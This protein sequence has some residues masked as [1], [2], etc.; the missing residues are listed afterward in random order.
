MAHRLTYVHPLFGLVEFE[1]NSL[2]PSSPIVRF[3]R[4]FDPADVISL[5]IPQLAHVTGANGGSVRFHRRGHGQLLAAFDEIERQGLLPNVRKFDGAFNMRLINPQRNPRPT[6]VRTPS[7]HSFGIA[8]DINAFANELVL[9]APLAPI[10]KHF[11][12]KW[13]KSFNDPM[14]FEIETWI[15]S[16]R[17]LTKSVTVLRNGAPIAI[18]AANI[19]GHIYAAVDDFL[20]VFGGQVTATGDKITVKNTKGVAKAFDI[21]TLRGR[22]YAQLTLL[23][24]HFGMAMDWNNVSKTANLT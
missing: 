7:N 24:G 17:P 2:A 15:D 19:E 9:N 6:Q 20:T 5:R 11:G 13:G 16:P 8:V 4:G 14:H 18:D 21:Q 10:F 12:F 23:S 3:I 1:T 22:T